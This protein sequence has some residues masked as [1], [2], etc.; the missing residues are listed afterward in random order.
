MQWVGNYLSLSC[1]KVFLV[2]FHIFP[3]QTQP[4][5]ILMPSVVSVDSQVKADRQPLH[6][7]LVTRR[8]VV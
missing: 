7:R 6:R 1:E 3:V 8:D 5:P 4:T 2:G